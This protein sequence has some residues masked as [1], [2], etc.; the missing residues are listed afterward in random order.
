MRTVRLRLEMCLP[1]NAR[2]PLNAVVTNVI[3]I[4]IIKIVICLKISDASIL[5]L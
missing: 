2:F 3:I 5:L 1:F 4:V